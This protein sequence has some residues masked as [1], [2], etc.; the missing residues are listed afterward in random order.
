VLAQRLVRRVCPN[1]KE[2]AE[3]PPDFAENLAMHGISVDHVWKG[4]GCPRCHNTGYSGRVGLY[5]MLVLD[6]TLRDEVTKNPNVTAFRRLCIERGMRTLRE[7]GFR[8][9]GDGLTTVEEV[10]RVTHSAN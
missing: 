3:V 6:D 2:Q 10:L 7:D 9:A 1:C 4:V 5:E 8:K